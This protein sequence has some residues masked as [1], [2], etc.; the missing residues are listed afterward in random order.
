MM[1]GISKEDLEALIWQ[2]IKKINSTLSTFKHIKKMVVTDE[3]MIK[4]TTAKIKKIAEIEKTI[5]EI[6]VKE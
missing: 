2:D 3:P 6:K 4:T 5:K 1:Q